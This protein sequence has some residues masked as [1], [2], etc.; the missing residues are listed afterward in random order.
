MALYPPYP[1]VQ[2]KAQAELQSVVGPHRFPTFADMDSLPFIA[3]IVKEVLRWQPVTCLG[4]IQVPIRLDG[5]VP[6]IL[7]RYRSLSNRRGGI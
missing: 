4:T 7:S 3:A 6:D 1:E 2:R 5:Y